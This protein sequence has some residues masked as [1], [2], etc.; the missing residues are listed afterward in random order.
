MAAVQF[1]ES[2]APKANREI[3]RYDVEIN[4]LISE[5]LLKV[6][7]T[8]FMTYKPR[9]GVQKHYEANVLESGSLQVLGQTFNAPSY[10][11]LAGIQDAGSDRQTVN[12]WTRWKT[13]DGKTLADL[14]EQF[15]N[16]KPI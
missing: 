9:N 10:A 4:D 15:L 16:T 1:L 5:N 8:L 7:D 11:A 6:G 12:G 13:S 2:E 3:T 14:R